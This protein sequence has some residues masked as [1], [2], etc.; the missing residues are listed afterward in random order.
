MQIDVSQQLKAP[1][2]SLRN[3]DVSEVIDIFGDGINSQV[4]GKFSL[5]RTNRG[6]LVKGTLH[7]ELE[8]TCNRCLDLFSCPLTLN[9]EEECFPTTDV[10]TNA[11]LPIP[12]E[13]GCFVIDEHYILDLT[14]AIRQYA[15]LAIPMKP[16]CRQDCAGLCSHC[17]HN[18]NQG[19]CDC[20]TQVADPRWSKLLSLTGDSPAK[21]RKG[22]E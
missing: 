5:M 14:E 6:I 12:D 1:I 19:A 17:G 20:P 4:Q 22:T 15:V 13:P 8:I 11:S 16:L 2:G 18:L 10:V 7:T 21:E 3:Y 9:L